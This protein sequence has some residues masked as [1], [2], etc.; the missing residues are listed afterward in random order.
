MQFQRLSVVRLCTPEPPP[1]DSPDDDRIQEAHLAYLAGLKERG[2]IALNGPIRFRDSPELRGM[3]LYTVDVD[4]A[5]SLA[6]GDPAVKAGWFD[7][8]V[9][10]WWIPVQ[11]VTL[12]DRVDI[13]TES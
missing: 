7:V 3:T 13:D 4:E 9:D 10:S 1:P 12:G 8:V 5:R 6:M 11:P 2:L